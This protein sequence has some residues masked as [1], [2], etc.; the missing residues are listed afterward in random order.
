MQSHHGGMTGHAR[1]NNRRRAYWLGL[2]VVVS[3]L[4]IARFGMQPGTL[5]TNQGAARAGQGSH[6]VAAQIPPRPNGQVVRSTVG[7]TR[8]QK[9]RAYQHYL[10]L[11]LAFEPNMGQA[12]AEVG[13]TARAE[14]YSLALSG[15]EAVLGLH[16]KTAGGQSASIRM[17]LVGGNASPAMTGSER[18]ASTSNYLIGNQPANWRIGVPNYSRVKLQS[19][20]PGVDLVYYGRQRQLEYDFVLAPGADPGRIQM[21]VDG[22]N[23]GA[24][25]HCWSLDSRGNLRLLVPGGQVTLEKPV[26]YQASASGAGRNLVSGNFVARHSP[27][28]LQVA[29]NVGAYDRT[30]PLVIDPTLNYST[31]LGGTGSDTGFAIAVDSTGKVYITGQTG[32]TDFP[33][34]S[35]YQGHSAGSFDAFVAKFDPT[36]SGASS[37]LYS[38]YLGG[39][40][41]DT[42]NAIAIDSSGNIILAGQTLSANFPVTATAYQP[43]AKLPG[44][45]TCFVTS[46]ASSGT[47]LNYSTYLSG[48]TS[49]SAQALAVDSTGVIYLTGKT[50]STDFPVTTNSYLTAI[51]G[52]EDAFVSVINPTLSGVNS[53]VY[54]TFLG[55]SGTDAGYGI[56]AGS[57]GIV[58]LTGSTNSTDFPKTTSAYQSTA[59]GGTC[60]SAAC[61]DAFVAEMNT[62]LAGTAALVYSTYL[63]GNLSDQGSAI[64]ADSSGNV[65]ITGFTFSSNFPV[66]AGIY[67]SGLLGA[68]N[69]FVAKLNPAASGAASL[70]YSTFLGGSG[71][72]SG[73]GVAV[74]SGGN[75][76]ITGVT[77]STNFPTASPTQ[78]ANGGGTSD[79]FVA[80][81]SSNGSALIFSTYLGGSGQD[82]SNGIA[83]DSSGNIY[84]T[85]FTASNNFPTSNAYN[86]A[87]TGTLQNAFVS[88]FGSTTLP[89][90]TASPTSLTF[91]SEVLGV[92]APTQTVTFT[93][94]GD[95]ILTVSGIA[96][97]GDFTQ[98]NSCI[99]TGSATGSLAAGANCTITVTFTPVAIGAR[100]GTLTISDNSSSGGTQTVALTGTGAAP[101]V[102]LT[103][104]ALTFTSQNVNTT[105]AVQPVTLSTTGSLTISNVAITGNFALASGTTCTNGATV[106]AGSSCVLNVTFTPATAGT[107]N[108]SIVL[109]DNASTS[110][111]T[112]SLT[113]TGSGAVVS[114]SPSTGLTFPG[115]I[116]NTASTATPVTLTNTGNAVLSSIAITIAGTNAGDF[117]ETNNCGTTLNASASCSINV[118]FK[119]TAGGGRSATLSIADSVAGS[120]QTVP[121]SGTGSDFSVSAAQSTQSVSPGSSATYTLSITPVGG[122]NQAIALTCSDPAQASQCTI[123]PASVTPTTGAVTATVTATTTA[124]V[125]PFSLK[126]MLPPAGGLRWPATWLLA[127]LALLGI[128]AL[129]GRRRPALLLA[130]VLLA[131][132]MMAACGG[133][134]SS[135]PPV[136]NGTPAGSYTL[137]VTGTA[138]SLTHTA[139]LTLTVN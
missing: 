77:T 12:P 103:A 54:S 125:A 86:A 99:P 51:A 107:L 139:N 89:V 115:Q 82:A 56:A 57:S 108:G 58:Y 127:L 31:Y 124:L 94:Q 6:R 126:H 68:Q 75:T 113:G 33:T 46:L 1:N 15:P 90:G 26:I 17:R 136:N 118:T 45:P 65:Y 67:Q 40:D 106:A 110:S 73:N 52:G 34:A 59:G 120:P 3:G 105:S 138:G 74:D 5:H 71:A 96:T 49:D 63:G 87:L 2:M 97:S 111:Q 48:S 38:T 130:G 55:G 88:T 102:S 100:T 44:Q 123:S 72:D 20:Y 10:S 29:F 98:T 128:A 47:T 119:P 24:R 4:A 62:T 39:T 121:L 92:A 91:P 131:A 95:N 8:A 66:T 28:G 135:T 14:G 19:V 25:S 129:A 132:L 16:G 133:S 70:V 23:C 35:P 7:V 112:I 41:A 11:P 93:N 117:T 9:S 76:Y 64:A 78:A 27:A 137:T 85:G 134:S 50:S 84:V 104:S 83:V 21:A 43:A 53:L 32:S 116:V 61:S 109:T 37:L 18:A 36:L 114:L 42:A 30:R 122:F 101:V 60:G 79:G 22:L 69:A 80:K 13:F 81:L